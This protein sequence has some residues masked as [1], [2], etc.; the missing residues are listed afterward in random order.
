MS[1][2]KVIIFENGPAIYLRE[3][4]FNRSTGVYSGRAVNGAYSF[5]YN[6]R[7]KQVY[8]DGA[9]IGN[10]KHKWIGD[11][12]AQVGEHMGD[13]SAVIEDAR[14]RMLDGEPSNYNLTLKISEK[15]FEED[16]SH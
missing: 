15:D 14:L 16:M 5:A 4:K 10:F 6:T 12:N 8:G 1:V 7:S 11:A 9:F 13:Y 2:D 3:T